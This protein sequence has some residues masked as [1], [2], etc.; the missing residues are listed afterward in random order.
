MD[1]QILR[2][3]IPALVPIVGSIAFAVSRCLAE[4]NALS[5]LPDWIDTTTVTSSGQRAS[6]C[7]WCGTAKQESG[8]CKA[9]GGPAQ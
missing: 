1:E 7:S 4:Q 9:C 3:I 8:N 5:E 6:E 2:A